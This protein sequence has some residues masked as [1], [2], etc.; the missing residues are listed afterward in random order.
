VGTI[1]IG[2]GQ[3]GLAVSRELGLR[4]VD[5]VVLEADSVGSSW[6]GRWDSFTLVTPNWTLDLPGQ[7]Y[8]GDDPEGHVA[9]DEIVAYLDRY[10]RLHAGPIH[11]G[12]RVRRLARHRLGFE[13]V[14]SEGPLV[15]ES[16]V[17]ATGSFTRPH[18]PPYAGELPGNLR[19]LDAT[20][21]R[22]PSDL[23]AGRVLVIGA[24]QTGVQLAEE[25]HLAGRE[26]VVACGRA[27]W[28]PRRLG[29]LDT[30]T[31]VNRTS[32]L[33]Q[34]L[35]AL[36][37]PAA[38][39][40]ANF[41]ATGR[42]G[43]HDLHFRVL[44]KMGVELVGRIIGVSGRTVEFADDLAESV[45]FGDARYDDLR[46]LLRAE[47]GDEVPEMPDPEPFVAHPPT[48]LELRPDD[49]V[50]FASGFRPDYAGWVEFPVFDDLG[51][52]VVDEELR[53]AVPGLYF[54][55]AHFLRTRRSGLLFGV[56]AD[57]ALVADTIASKPPPRQ[58]VSRSL[59]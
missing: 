39:L 26:V 9:R 6:R 24:G 35:S 41:Q 38:R 5:H 2:G 28:I 10:A 13:L 48:R 3:A 20:D 55:G 12:V 16:V 53:T 44:Q 31:W 19:V 29:D 32:F 36:P 8:D 54:C 52:P 56:G 1:V 25:L 51:F 21:Y 23:P 37:A 43:G 42:N 45:A 49:A 14:T 22:N 34:P 59:D 40:E 15:A 11:T 4:G 46:R 27:P 30:V 18:R 57:A 50:I 17:V 47:L 33:D 58:Q 7:P